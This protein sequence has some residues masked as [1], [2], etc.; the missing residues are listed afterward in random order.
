[1][2]YFDLFSVDP[3]TK[4]ATL[5]ETCHEK[6]A[7]I[8]YPETHESEWHGYI[9]YPKNNPPNATPMGLRSNQRISHNAATV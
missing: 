5:T 4:I 3:I 8:P 2:T 1:M 9:Q 7:L 6:R